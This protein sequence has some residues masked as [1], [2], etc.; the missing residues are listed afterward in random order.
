VACRWVAPQPR[1]Q[2]LACETCR[3]RKV[4]CRRPNG[5]SKP[6]ERCAAQGLTCTTKDTTVDLPT[7]YRAASQAKACFASNTPSGAMEHGCSPGACGPLAVQAPTAT[8]TAAEVGQQQP[9]ES[10]AAPVATAA[11]TAATSRYPFSTF[12]F[13]SS[14]LVS[15]SSLPV[16]VFSVCFALNIDAPLIGHRSLGAPP[17]WI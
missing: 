6:C 7:A 11:A 8:A 13:L 10:V 14:S 1:A 3:R 16:C 9:A 17:V 5:R 15:S 2:E 12:G 4:S